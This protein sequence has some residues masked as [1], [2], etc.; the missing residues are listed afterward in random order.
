MREYFNGWNP[1]VNKAYGLSVLKEWNKM[2]GDPNH[3][4]VKDQNNMDVYQRLVWDIWMP[5]VRSIIL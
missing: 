5:H 3:V 4:Y 2:L 1:L